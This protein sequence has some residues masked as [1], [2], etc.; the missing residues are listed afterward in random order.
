MLVHLLEG[1]TQVALMISSSTISTALM[2]KHLSSFT[3]VWW[4]KMERAMVRVGGGWA[5]LA[6]YLKV[7]VAHHGSNKCYELPIEGGRTDK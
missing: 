2:T 1:I 4:E 5:D 6:E 3:F 7:Y